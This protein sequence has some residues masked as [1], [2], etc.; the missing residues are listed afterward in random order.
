MNFVKGF[1]FLFQRQHR[2]VV[3]LHRIVERFKMLVQCLIKYFRRKFKLY[4]MKPF[5]YIE[6]G[7]ALFRPQKKICLEKNFWIIPKNIKSGA[8]KLPEASLFLVFLDT[9]KREKGRKVRDF[10]FSHQFLFNHSAIY[11]VYSKRTDFKLSEMS[12]V[13]I[14]KIEEKLNPPI[15]DSVKNFEIDFG[16]I[17]NFH[18]NLPPSVSFKNF[19]KR[20]GKKYGIS[21]DFRDIVGLYLHATGG[22]YD[23]FYNN[24]FQKIAQLQTVFETIVGKP[25]EKKFCCGFSHFVEPWKDFLSK[26]LK[27]MGV[28]ENDIDFIIKIKMFLNK[29]A[30]VKYIH[31]SKYLNPFKLTLEELKKGLPIKPSKNLPGLLKKGPS[32]WTGLDWENVCA[33][34]KN[35][36]KYMIWLKYL[37]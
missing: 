24:I 36:V 21:D 34:Y 9:S 31:N 6:L 17:D 11:G 4:K 12:G 28:H 13:N 26:N 2:H 1:D 14:D 3:Y 10:V 15:K 20:F 7:G 27:G 35:I 32:K 25:E 8:I 5:Q 33:S 23:L 19:Y 18:T 37:K 30:R 22:I 29:Q 16:Q